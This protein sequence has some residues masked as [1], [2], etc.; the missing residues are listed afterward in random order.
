MATET[1]AAVAMKQRQGL[2]TT[3]ERRRIEAGWQAVQDASFETLDVAMTDF[4]RAER[5]VDFGTG[6]RAADALHLAIALRHGCELV[7]R[8]RALA[9]AA[10]AAGTTAY[11]LSGVDSG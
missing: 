5:L 2:I 4:A 10:A 9:V 3:A 7:T 8:D 11:L 1:V 6:L